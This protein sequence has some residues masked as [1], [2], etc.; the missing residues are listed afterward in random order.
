MARY[1][2]AAGKLFNYLAYQNPSANRD[3]PQLNN[4]NA[5]LV[6]LAW[7]FADEAVAPARPDAGSLWNRRVEA[8]RIPHTDKTLLER[9]LGNAN[10]RENY[11]HLCCSWFMTGKEWPDKLILRSGWD[12]GDFFGLV[13]LHPTSFPA[14]PG[15]IMGLN[16]WGAPFTQ[17]VTS[18]GASAENR[19][20]VEDV[21]GSAKRR[22]HE[23]GNRIDEFWKRGSMPD[24]RSEVTLFE[25][26][27]AAT[28]ASVRVEN[29]DG[30]PVH[31]DREFVFVKNRFLA[32]RETVTFEEGFKAR[33]A[34]LWNTQN[35]GPQIGGHWANTFISAPVGNNGTRSMPT[36]PADLLVWFAPKDDCRLQSVDR[37]AEDPRAVA[38]PNQL[39]YVWEG[40]AKAGQKNDVHPSLLPARAV[41]T[42]AIFKQS[43][44]R[45][46]SNLPKRLAGHC[47]CIGD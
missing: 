28:F 32:T 34:P 45:S 33:M 6:A 39:R 2:W 44:S 19:L 26:T 47:G 21:G 31:Y 8:V 7:L 38:C 3:L 11:G 29:M 12:A 30:L 15:G 40:E 46:E 36:P 18:K 1:R 23:D 20:I 43:E 35:I 17:I 24:I 5:W 37:V 9:L 41:S 13:E 10:S 22:Y 16:R 25:D 27:P 4:G 14:N 42:A